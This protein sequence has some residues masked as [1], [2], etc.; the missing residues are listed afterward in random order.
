MQRAAPTEGKF[1]EGQTYT[2]A[3]IFILLGINPH[4]RGGNWFTGYHQHKGEWFIFSTVG[5]PGRTGHD[6]GDAW[7]GDMFHWSGRTGS[8]RDQPAIQSM[9]RRDSIVRLFWRSDNRDKFT[10]AGIVTPIRIEDRVPV[11]VV[12]KNDKNVR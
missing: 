12:W 6:Y 8:D 5:A 4:P 2:R 11:L 3:D 7:E 1:L 9:L 10:Y